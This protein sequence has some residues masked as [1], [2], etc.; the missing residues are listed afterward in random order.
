MT[1]ESGKCIHYPLH[2]LKSIPL[3]TADRH[4]M[5]LYILC[6]RKISN[7]YEWRNRPVNLRSNIVCSKK[8]HEWLSVIAEEGEEHRTCIP[9]KDRKY[10]TDGWIVGQM[11]QQVRII[12]PPLLDCLLYTSDAADE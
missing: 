4:D 7:L 5:G 10:R 11:L 3:V 6:M 12:L 8:I 2:I 9:R 1:A